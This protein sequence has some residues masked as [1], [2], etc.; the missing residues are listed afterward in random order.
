VSRSLWFLA[1]FLFALGIG[2]AV[3][4]GPLSGSVAE[5]AT[6][7]ASGEASDVRPDAQ[8]RPSTA[9]ALL[10][11]TREGSGVT[12]QCGELEIDERSQA[13]YT[14]CGQSPRVALLTAA[15]LEEWQTF[16]S[17]Y[18]AFEYAVQAPAGGAA[19]AVIR[20]NLDGQGA[21]AATVQEQASVADYAERVFNRLL[22]DEA[23]AEILADIR[24]DVMIRR[25]V[26]IEAIEILSVEPVTWPD[27]CLGLRKQGTYCGQVASEGY[28]IVLSVRDETLEYRADRYGNIGLETG[29]PAGMTLPPLAR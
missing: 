3:I 25:G 5:P 4:L 8:S 29:H 21:R 16:L 10:R 14:P 24:L 17:T 15:E 18:V 23:R 26:A 19:T 28:R 7:P 1:G 27:S 9:S 20:L 11:W 13:R 12:A 2:I 6:P 22:A